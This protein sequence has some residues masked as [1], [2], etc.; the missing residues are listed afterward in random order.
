MHFHY[1]KGTFTLKATYVA[2]FANLE[3]SLFLLCLV[4]DNINVEQYEKNIKTSFYYC[5][6]LYFHQSKN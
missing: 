2:G 6:A 4:K 3:V 1:I 5:R